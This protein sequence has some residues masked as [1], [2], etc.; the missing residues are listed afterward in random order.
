M[1]AKFLNDVTVI[2]TWYGQ[3]NHLFN[4]M[5]FYNTMAQTYPKLT[6]RLIVI[7]DGHEKGR[8]YFHEVIN[9]HRDRFDLTGID[10]LKDVGFNSHACRNLG[11]KQCKTDWML[12][13][14]VDCFESPGM[15]N[16]LRFFK[17]LNPNMYCFRNIVHIRIELMLKP[18]VLI[19]PL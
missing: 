12:L 6:P 18:K 14:D 16:H 5:Q 3:E 11:V 4:Q 8:E 17:N 15:Y 1:R 10:V 13:M 7:N 9:V 19:H 2:M